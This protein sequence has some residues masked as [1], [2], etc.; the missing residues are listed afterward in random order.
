MYF[1]DFSTIQKMKMFSSQ[2]STEVV[3]FMQECKFDGNRLKLL[4]SVKLEPTLN[5]QLDPCMHDNDIYLC[6]TPSAPK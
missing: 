5:A 2:V 4:T 6:S 1:A 3:T